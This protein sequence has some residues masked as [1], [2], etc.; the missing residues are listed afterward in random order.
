M[1][2]IGYDMHQLKEGESLF[3]GGIE[4]D[5]EIGTVAHSD[6]DVLL[7]SIIDAL[8]GAM[9]KG[10]IGD[11]FPDTDEQYKNADSKVLYKEIIEILYRENYQIINI[12]VTI[13]TEKPKISPLKQKLKESIANLSKIHINKVNIKAT[14]NEK[15]G[16]IGR[17]EGIVVLSAC[18]LEKA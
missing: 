9:C 7:H 3:L 11:F 5:S 1:I 13:V 8:L 16:F 18:Q 12:D 17:N 4:I 6:G 15:R 10:D 2:G 14:T